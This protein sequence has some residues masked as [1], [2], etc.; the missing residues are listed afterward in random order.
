MKTLHK[1]YELPAVEH[2]VLEDLE[3]INKTLCSIDEDCCAVEGALSS[4][5]SSVNDIV[6]FGVHTDQLQN[7]TI[8]NI[9]SNRYLVVNSDGSKL[10]TIEGGGDAGGNTHEV[11]VKKSN[12]NYDTKWENLFNIGDELN[13]V[14]VDGS[15]DINSNSS[16]IVENSASACSSHSAFYSNQIKSNKYD[17]EL[18]NSYVLTNSVEDAPFDEVQKATKNNLGIVK[19]GDGVN[20]D[21]GSISVV[22]GCDATKTEYGTVMPGD[23]FSVDDGE[24]S[25]DGYSI[26]SSS[27]AG[28][29]KIGS[30]F[31]IN[32][33]GG[34]EM[35]ISGEPIIYNLGKIKGISGNKIIVEENV[36]LYRAE[37]SSDTDFTID[38][39]NFTQT[40]DISFYVEIVANRVCDI[41]FND[42]IGFS[43][44]RG[45]SLFK[46]SKLLGAS[47]FSAELIK[48]EGQ[49]Q[50][51]LT[52]HTN[53]EVNS[54][55][56]V[57]SSTS[58]EAWIYDFVY[59][60]TGTTNMTWRNSPRQLDFAFAS[61]VLVDYLWWRDDT[62]DEENP[63][64]L[65]G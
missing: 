41:K 56:Y 45:S 27:K 24:I 18:N 36:G 42:E 30:G 31:G 43:V 10:H 35:I 8:D 32:E 26:A 39:S 5:D 15:S 59:N 6:K 58:G 3:K 49:N 2:E 11:L 54:D 28:I 14:S 7:T 64:T 61:P 12:K 33:N 51:L 62:F 57:T 19:I 50:E 4:L 46:V 34:L 9:E 65:N 47:K 55:Y 37:I 29:V 16:V 1:N 44:I 38:T 40:K 23:G 48:V 13:V 60:L 17:L 25:F 52:L 53:Q 21:N 20:V 22:G 63:I